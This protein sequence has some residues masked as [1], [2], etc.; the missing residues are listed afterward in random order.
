MNQLSLVHPDLQAA[1]KSFPK[2]GYSQRFL[3]LI[4]LLM[5][6]QSGKKST[7]DIVIENRFIPSEDKKAQ[8]RLRIYKPK[9]LTASAP[10]ILW[11]HG[12]G[13]I[14]G[15]PEL[16]ES[17]Y[18]QMLQELGI[19]I[20]AP[21]YRL[22]PEH[23]FPRPLD[24]CYE[25]LRW[26]HTEAKSLGID[27]SRLAIGGESAGA[28]LAAALIQLVHDRKEFKPSFQ[29]LIYPMLDDKTALRNDLAYS[30][31]IVWSQESNR[32]GWESY[33]GTHY[34]KAER[35]AYAV[36]ARREDLSGLPPTWLGVGTLDIFHDEDILYAQ[37]LKEAGVNVELK[38]VEGAFHGFDIMA[39]QTAVAQ[40]FRKSQI[41]ALKKYLF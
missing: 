12:G 30:D 13:Y 2:I 11:I 19:V 34:S 28:G 15:K 5:K 3:W 14:I 37:R 40:E 24:D 35:P 20:I 36:P 27:T 23:P 38:L 26:M 10:C 17:L 4:R 9:N 22:A 32:F 31:Y 29:L 6:F 18:F 21:A 8:I 39:S 25:T 1:A 33:L 16:N 41:A 7:D